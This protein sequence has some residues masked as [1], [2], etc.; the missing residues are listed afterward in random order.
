[1]GFLKDLGFNGIFKIAA[2]LF[3]IGMIAYVTAQDTDNSDKEKALNTIIVV[4]QSL[5]VLLMYVHENFTMNQLLIIWPV[6]FL[7]QAA[8]AYFRFKDKETG[9]I[10]AFV[11]GNALMIFISMI[12]LPIKDRSKTAEKK[13]TSSDDQAK[14]EAKRLLEDS[15]IERDVKDAYDELEAIQQQ[16]NNTPK[17]KRRDQLTKDKLSRVV[18]LRETIQSLT[19]KSL[20]VSPG[21]TGRLESLESSESES[22]IVSS[23]GGRTTVQLLK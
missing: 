14:R 7:L 9:L 19:G 6:L 2:G 22:S 21:R 17:G 12:R 3:S 15:A 18:E 11:G 20:L 8:C 23:P 16:I 10:W 4:I 5:M 1:M 13:D